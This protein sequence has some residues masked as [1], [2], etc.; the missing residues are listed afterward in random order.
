[1]GLL[2]SLVGAFTGSSPTSGT[3]PLL[4][5]LGGLLTQNG[6]LRGLMSKFTQSGHGDAFA[7]W[8]GMG[9]NQ[10]ISPQ[11]VHNTLGADQMQQLAA[12]LGMDPAQASS[13]LA[14]HLP[15]IVDKLTPAGAVDPNADHHQ[16]L[17]ALLP[18]LLQSMG[19]G[20]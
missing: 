11:E 12:K 10:A 6:G 3:N 4:S 13:F 9:D 20:G 1:M 15:K 7:S 2:D 18:S 19:A 8:V 5:A 14:E 16:G 17:A